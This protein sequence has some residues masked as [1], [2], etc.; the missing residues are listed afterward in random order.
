MWFATSS[1]LYKQ[2]I[3]VFPNKTRRLPGP[4]AFHIS[5]NGTPHPLV[6]ASCSGQPMLCASASV[7]SSCATLLCMYA[8]KFQIHCSLCETAQDRLA[9][10]V[11]TATSLGTLSTVLLHVYAVL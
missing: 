2:A 6:L 7:F 10:G 3:H 1:E 5:I 8:A 9:R 11:Q 4:E